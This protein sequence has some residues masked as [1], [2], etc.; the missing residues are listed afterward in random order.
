M[1]NCAH[2][3][4]SVNDAGDLHIVQYADQPYEQVRS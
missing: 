4:V 3:I 2:N 1:H